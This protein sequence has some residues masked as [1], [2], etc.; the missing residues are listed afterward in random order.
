MEGLLSEKITFKQ[1][2]AP[3][4]A[5]SAAV[6]G[7]RIKL[8]GGFKVAVAV[9]MG[10]SAAA[11]ANFSLLQHDAETAGNSKALEI[12]NHYYTKVA[13]AKSFTKNEVATAT[14]SF[15]LSSVFAADEGIV[16]FEILA[17]DLDVN[18]GFAYVS[19]NIADST[20]AKVFAGV[21]CLHDVRKGMAYSTEV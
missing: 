10:D 4:D 21:Y 16:V 15:D 13:S 9:T 8:D 19:L 6:V 12:K 18:N 20:A 17:E 7:A 5:N 3:A 11:V 2:A 14:G 1:V